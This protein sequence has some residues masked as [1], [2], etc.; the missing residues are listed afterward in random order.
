MKVAHLI[1]VHACPNQLARLVERL[2]HPD[3]V[4]F[5]HVDSKSAINQFEQLFETRTNIFFIKNRVSIQWATYSMV[6]A[7]LNGFKEILASGLKID[8]VNL[9]SGQD[10]PLKPI[11]EFHAFLKANPGKAFMECLSVEKEWKEAIS[12]VTKYH[13]NH[14]KIPGKFKL[15]KLFNYFLP[16][17]KMPDNLIAVGRSQWFTITSEQVGFLIKRLESSPNIVKFFTY[18]WAPDEMIFQT[19]LFNSKYQKDIV[20][21]NL[22]YIDWSDRKQNPKLL[23]SQDFNAFMQSGKFF[24]RKFQENDDVLDMIDKHIC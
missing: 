4:F 5:I 19:L 14:W 1:L 24:A 8:Y 23:S 15:Q 18:S 22:R 2:T 16:N 17:R 3:A 20:G 12:R 10:Y 9:L 13:F 6:E 11:A 21:D 7:T